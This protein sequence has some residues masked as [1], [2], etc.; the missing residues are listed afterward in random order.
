MG[1]S[2][3]GKSRIG[4][5]LADT[6]N[7]PFFDGDDFHP[8]SNI[9]KMASGEPLTDEERLGWLNNL[10]KL[11]VKQLKNNHLVISCS[12]LKESYR[13]ILKQNIEENCH[14]IFLSGSFDTIRERLKN[15][16]DHFMPDNLL[17]S[18]FDSLEEPECG[19]KIDINKSPQ[20]ITEKILYQ[21]KNE[22]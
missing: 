19:I 17:Q 2:G 1:V 9:L 3:C 4:K 11:A 12:A 15:R 7:I 21:L 5:K 18:Q 8:E 20:E 6:L 16:K 14:W 22:I 10:N 13:K